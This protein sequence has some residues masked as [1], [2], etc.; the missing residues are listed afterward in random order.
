MNSHPDMQKGFTLVSTIFIIVVLAIL[1]SFITVLATVQHISTAQS[2]EGVRAYYAA[3]S[4]MEWA[5]YEATTTA[6]SRDLIC[7]APPEAVPGTQNNP[8]VATV[9]GFTIDVGCESV[10]AVI[11]AVNPYYVD[12]L[13]ITAKRGIIGSPDYVTRKIV[14]TVSY[15]DT[16]P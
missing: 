7:P 3:Y 11:E 14:A 15:K 1:G 9:N 12:T 5:I 16:L 13:T 4:G 6:V 2:L 8:G 10:G